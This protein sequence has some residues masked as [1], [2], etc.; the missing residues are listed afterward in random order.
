MQRL[1]TGVLAAVIGW[2]SWAAPDETLPG[3]QPLTIAGDIPSQML[4]GAHRLIERKIAESLQARQAHWHRDFASRDAYETSVAPNRERFRQKIGVVDAR[5]SP[6]MME[7]F[8]DDDN[9]P[10]VAECPQYRV[11]QVRWPVL[12]GVFAEGL[13]VEP[14]R[15][16]VGQVIVLSDADQ[17]PEQI[18]GLA[19]GLAPGEQLALQFARVGFRV[20]VPTLVDRSSTFA[21]HPE[22]KMTPQSNREWIYRQAFQLGRHVIGY[23]VQRVLA[24][25]DYLQSSKPAL[26]VAV[27]GQGEGGLDAFYAAACDTRLAGALVSG[28]FN[29][30]QRVWAE[31]IYRNVWGLLEEFGD[32]EIATLIAPRPLVVAYGRYPIV[33]HTNGELTEPT[34]ASVEGEFKRMDSLLKDGFQP[35]RF[36][37]QIDD[38]FLE[39]LHIKPAAA[40]STPPAT[41]D[42]RKSFDPL[43]RQGRTVRELE[44]HVQHLVRASE[45]V[46]EKYFLH[47]V[48]PKFAD[49]KWT[50][51]LRFETFDA[52]AFEEK[53]RPYRQ[54]LW[55]EV[56]GR[57]D[58][59]YAPPNPRSR[60]TGQ[61]DKWTSYDV[62][63][64][65]WPEFFTH[66]VLLVPND[67]KPG[68]RRPVV[69]CQHGRQG[70][71]KDTI[72]DKGNAYNAFS[73][74]LADRGFIVFAHQNLHYG[75][76]RYRWL[77]RKAN[78]VKASLFSFIVAQHD[79]SLRFLATLPFVDDKRIAFYGLSYGG[80]TAMRVPAVLTNY[81]LSICS[82]DFNQW[83]EKVASTDQKF[84]FMYSIEWEMPYFNMSQTFDYAEMAYLI[85]PRPFMVERGHNDR[86]GRDRWVGYEYAKVRNLY[87]QMGLGAHTAIEWFNGGH[88]VNAQGTFEFLDRELNRKR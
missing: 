58:E 47:A 1:L 64:D 53:S 27:A 38:A 3:T 18:L 43:A 86:V 81:C 49:E 4:D 2:A 80:E 60:K 40:P 11:W 61:T 57:I 32:A 36:V 56:L 26:A 77:S 9:P 35:R 31:P 30:R 28:Y 16:P 74:K 7:R 85:F 23:E 17:T 20:V 44:G 65:V 83:T 69:V 78:G 75:E 14:T 51:A 46:R 50:T 19:P 48:E 5:V 62:V 8:G 22:I 76:D 54:T 87:D 88:A 71:P 79:V 10:L 70:Q 15:D 42:R 37:G 72:D 68:E 45:Q 24:A 55:T 59:P 84:S 21:G 29:D 6:V 73:A 67:L 66:G 13:L 63:L 82:G 25:A 41:E 34:P 12:P 39:M 33:K 52:R